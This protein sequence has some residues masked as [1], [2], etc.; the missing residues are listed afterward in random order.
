M[1]IVIEAQYGA[2]SGTYASA[3]KRCDGRLVV[4]MGRPVSLTVR[5]RGG[6]ASL[7]IGAYDLEVRLAEGESQT[8]WWSPGSPG[9][10]PIGG[11]PCTGDV[12]SLGGAL[13]VLEPEDFAPW[14]GSGDCAPLDPGDP[15]Y[16]AALFARLGCASC[17]T[18]GPPGQTGPDLAGLAGKTVTLIDGT[19]RVVDRAYLRE[20]ITQPSRA[21]VEGYEAKMP[22]YGDQL[23]P[24]MI[25]ALVAYIVA[26]KTPGV[27]P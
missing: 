9:R 22:D 12:H 2:W 8:V 21:V 25:E 3:K 15:A 24:E 19:T 11:G 1:E 27:E 26:W 23:S 5:A 18:G 10:Q 14:L 16:G 6:P 13:D 7:C 20:S 4:P 17:H